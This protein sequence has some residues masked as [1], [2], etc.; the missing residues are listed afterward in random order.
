MKK[1][2]VKK[3]SFIKLAIISILAIFSVIAIAFASKSIVDGKKAV[4]AESYDNFS[5]N[6]FV[7]EEEDY[8]QYDIEHADW[9]E[10]SKKQ[11]DDLQLFTND[12]NKK[13]ELKR[14]TTIMSMGENAH[15]E[16][17]GEEI[18]DYI[19]KSVLLRPGKS[20][21]IGQEYG[22]IYFAVDE[23]KRYDNQL[24]AYVRYLYDDNKNITGKIPYVFNPDWCMLTVKLFIFSIDTQ[25]S[26]KEHNE[27][28]VRSEILLNLGEGRIVRS[29]NEENNNVYITASEYNKWFLA[30]PSISV[31]VE[32][33]YGNFNNSKNGIG[34]Y[35]ARNNFLGYKGIRT[36][37]YQLASDIQTSIISP[38]NLL[39]V[40]EIKNVSIVE[41]DKFNQILDAITG[42]GEIAKDVYDI[43]NIFVPKLAETNPYLAAA[44][45]IVDIIDKA[46]GIAENYAVQFETAYANNENNILTFPSPSQ[47]LTKDV[48]ASFGIN[49]KYMNK[50][51]VIDGKKMFNFDDG[52]ETP[53]LILGEVGEEEER[54]HY[55]ES[56]FQLTDTNIPTVLTS[57]FT[58][59]FAFDKSTSGKSDIKKFNIPQRFNYS[60]KSVN[61][62]DT[63]ANERITEGA[64][65]TVAYFNES[66]RKISLNV[67]QSGW[68]DLNL[69]DIMPIAK[70]NVISTTEN[71]VP[72]MYLPLELSDKSKQKI[73]LC[74]EDDLGTNTQNVDI[75][76]GNATVQ[77]YLYANKENS[78]NFSF[79]DISVRL[80][81]TSDESYAMNFVGAS[82]SA[83]LHRHYE[84]IPCDGQAQSLK[85]N[86]EDWGYYSVTSGETGIYRISVKNAEFSLYDPMFYKL[87]D[88]Q[89]SAEIIMSANQTYYICA[90][91]IDSGRLA[92]AKFEKISEKTEFDNGN[93]KKFEF[94]LSENKNS[95]IY[96]VRIGRTGIYTFNYDMGKDAAYSLQVKDGSLREY[97]FGVKKVYL[98]AGDYYFVFRNNGTGKTNGEVTV[99]FTPQQITT[100]KVKTVESDTY[101]SFIPPLSG[102]YTLNLSNG[103]FAAEA[104]GFAAN[105]E[106]RYYF[107][108]GQR[109]I[110]K[111]AKNV[112]GS[113][114]AN[115]SVSFTPSAKVTYHQN[116]NDKAAEFTTDI[117]GQYSFNGENIALYDNKLVLICDGK[118]GFGCKLTAGEKYFII[119]SGN[120]DCIVNLEGEK[121]TANFEA[122]ISEGEKYLK[123][124]APE[125][126]YYKIKAQYGATF[127]V[128]A[129][130]NLSSHTT[131]P[132][133]KDGYYLSKGCTY[134]LKAY[135]SKPD[136]ITVYNGKITALTEIPEGTF[137]EVDLNGEVSYAASYKFVPDATCDYTFI[138]S[139]NLKKNFKIFIDGSEFTFENGSNVLKITK[140][141]N[142]G[143]T[144]E[145]TF[146][147]TEGAEGTLIFGVSRST[148]D[149]SVSVD[150]AKQF[151]GAVNKIA[152]GGDKSEKVS[153]QISVSGASSHV[154]YNL[155]NPVKL[156]N[157]EEGITV[158][159]DG[160]V[161]VSNSLPQWT[162]F[163]VEVNVGRLQYGDIV[164]DGGV[165][166][167]INFLIYVDVEDIKILGENNEET[168]N[169]DIAHKQTINLT[170]AVFPSHAFKAESLTYDYADE[171]GSEYVELICEGYKAEVTAKPTA[172]NDTYV[173]IYVHCGDEFGVI[174]VVRVHTDVIYAANYEDI[175][176]STDSTKTAYEIVL[177]G[178]IVDKIITVPSNINYL[179]IRKG[180]SNKLTKVA[181]KVKSD[182]LFLIL[183]SIELRGVINA[184]LRNLELHFIGGVL[185]YGADSPYRSYTKGE[186]V[187]IARDL[188][189]TKADNYPVEIKAGNGFIYSDEDGINYPG[190]GGVALN[191]SGAVELI[192]VSNLAIYGGRGADGEDGRSALAVRQTPPAT[193]D[194][195]QD[196]VKGIDALPGEPGMHGG[197]GGAAIECGSLKIS[198]VNGVHIYGGDGGHGGAGGNGGNG[199]VAVKVLDTSKLEIQEYTSFTVKAGDGGNAGAGGDAGNGG[200]GGDG[201]DD[202][203]LFNGDEGPGGVGGNGGNGGLPGTPGAKGSSIDGQP[204]NATGN[205]GLYA[206]EGYRGLGGTG[207]CRGDKGITDNDVEDVAASGS[208]GSGRVR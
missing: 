147:L 33:K 164:L 195:R 16:A 138:F 201:G 153:A 95:Q 25:L 180:S 130:N 168:Y 93:E 1:I 77:L 70:L 46:V 150:N 3:K 54:R 76:S 135:L 96:A 122:N 66:E 165:S 190:D 181:I 20:A 193:A 173:K 49:T 56:I 6:E 175:N 10:Y 82:F 182:N 28:K 63:I 39:D 79:N 12:I 99:E 127:E 208:N 14:I 67:S 192:G 128:Y 42:R 51:E 45:I 53:N 17:M 120:K 157:G 41:Y 148:F 140:S 97:L 15:R 184:Y 71:E 34:I 91:R 131:E 132:F 83:N 143:K 31:S 146:N 189:I 36:N 200:H 115:F 166:K 160:K 106:N 179:K 178:D 2:S 78:F 57:S 159:G 112:A 129:Y 170:A 196:G 158:G 134:Y 174:I 18:F 11:L 43:V 149:F 109:Y 142:A 85:F 80:S 197:H 59:S 27:Y 98:T 171:D 9:N 116:F 144:Y 202:K 105:G 207:G 84:E 137:A 198:K 73:N 38:T 48:I 136:F 50:E 88:K 162:A 22:F 110:I 167:V 113:A 4:Y 24:K 8:N 121:I 21:Y 155:L 206:E 94:D 117:T 19:P 64:T 177:N 191:C 111:I 125:D 203:A 104:E 141:L 152:V 26:G 185:L 23:Y 133:T 55:S 5:S 32:N 40:T 101:F 13:R 119:N 163:A 169:I 186:D 204:Y 60:H 183:D 29:L 7:I 68:Y 156:A 90:K 145:I 61:L 81:D 62:F 176:I 69:A 92:F 124:I 72:G 154:N 100:E 161:T 118:E 103:N 74:I 102:Y 58:A 89:Q 172:P 87:N 205:D 47:G 107:N 194:E 123:F 139:R 52:K 188:K 75:S 35:Q 86:E 187:I 30:D 199:S 151:D 44:M 114:N 108:A 65:D 37:K 126:G